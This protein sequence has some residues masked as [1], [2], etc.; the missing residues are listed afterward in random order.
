M[1]VLLAKNKLALN[2]DFVNEGIAGTIFRGRLIG[3]TK[4]GE[5]P[6]VIPE[7]TGSAYISGFNHLVL[8]PDDPF[9]A[10][11]FLLGQEI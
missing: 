10:K 1:A 3:K 2:E 8:D 9:G 6:A 11:G 5:Y 4:V 7:I